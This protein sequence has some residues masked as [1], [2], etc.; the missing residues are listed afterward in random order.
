MLGAFKWV[1]AFLSPIGGYLADR[2]SRRHVIA[3]QPVRL[4]GG[5]LG[6]R[7]R[8]DLRRNCSGRAALMGISEAF[9]IPAALALIADFHTGPH[10]VARGR[11]APDGDLRGRH[12]RRLRRLR[13]RRPA[14]RL[15]VGLRR[16][17]RGR[18]A[19]RGAAAAPAAQRRRDRAE[20]PGADSRPLGASRELLTQP[21]RSSCWCSTSR[22]RRS[23]AGWC[24]TGCR[25]SSS[26]SSTSARARPACRRR[27]T[28]RSPRIVGAV[29][30]GWLADR[31]MRRT[32]RGRIFVSAIGMSLIVPAMFGV[33]NAGT[34]G[35]AIA[36]P[37]RSS[38]S[39]GDSSTATTCP[40]S[41]RSCGPSCA[42][43][44]T[45]S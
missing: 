10:A 17:R 14:P 18:H 24:A 1:Y 20:A 45:A 4:V 22:C 37:H 13:G 35:V 6:D 3:R 15:A 5:H 8:H 32:P 2:F 31:W 28:G 42:P 9:Y 11:R 43:P 27:S 21:A 34:L 29:V 7:A 26:S 23:P 41:A 39:A 38:A 40:S 30:G 19:L 12:P 25:P 16:L 33:G 36:V 44:A